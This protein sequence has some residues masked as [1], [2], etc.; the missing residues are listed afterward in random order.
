MADSQDIN[1][2][3][4]LNLI[5]HEVG[6]L[7]MSISNGF[8][9]SHISI[10]LAS[11]HGSLSLNGFMILDDL[12]DVLRYC[13]GRARILASGAFAEAIYIDDGAVKFDSGKG[14]EIFTSRKDGA[15]S[16]FDKFSE[17]LNIILSTK[18]RTEDFTMKDPS[19]IREYVEN[20]RAKEL[21]S[22]LDSV[23]KF[24]VEC[25]EEINLISEILFN[26]ASINGQW[27]GIN[28]YL[29][30]LIKEVSESDIASDMKERLVKVL[31]AP[32]E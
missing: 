30:D 20:T 3:V 2:H 26:K 11:L 22:L 8:Q 6:H 24:I 28:M 13:Q 9:C 31:N 12:N 4:K 17:H 27:L 21:N 5:K 14:N 16:D 7:L 1:D 29:S 10:S 15:A 18:I 23:R 32:P 19:Q 25:K